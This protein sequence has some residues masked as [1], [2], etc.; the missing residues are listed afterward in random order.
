M[1]EIPRNPERRN[2]GN[3]PIS[4]E[5]LGK[6]GKRHRFETPPP[7][8]YRGYYMPTHEYEF[9]PRVFNLLSHE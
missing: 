6:G 9:Y 4:Q 2:D 8:K 7:V 5:E 1:T 3:P